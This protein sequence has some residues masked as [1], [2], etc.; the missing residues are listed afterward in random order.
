M[1]PNA[2]MSDAWEY[3]FR[4]MISGAMYAGEPML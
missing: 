4:L 1:I 2:Q 3:E